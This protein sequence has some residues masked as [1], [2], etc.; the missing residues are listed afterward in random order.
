MLWWYPEVTSDTKSSD[1]YTLIL[2][3]VLRHKVVVGSSSSTVSMA[4]K[5]TVPSGPWLITAPRTSLGYNWKSVLL[6]GSSTSSLFFRSTSDTVTKISAADC[7]NCLLVKERQLCINLAKK[8][9]F[10]QDFV[11]SHP[12]IIDQNHT[13]Q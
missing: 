13:V 1:K 10:V 9:M 5:R 11:R 2:M 12:L 3:Q 7:Q 4:C 8:V 6:S